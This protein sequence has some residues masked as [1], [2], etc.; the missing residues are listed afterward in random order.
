M[1]KKINWSNGN[2]DSSDT[3]R[4]KKA[5][6]KIDNLG[7]KRFMKTAFSII[8]NLSFF[9]SEFSENSDPPDSFHIE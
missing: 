8:L 2:F 7:L 5:R 9:W 4:G 6:K 1:L 3:N